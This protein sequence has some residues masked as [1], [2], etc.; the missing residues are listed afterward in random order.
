MVC[1]IICFE[2]A[3]GPLVRD[4]VRDGAEV[5]VVTTNNR[6]YRR[7][8]NSA[9]HVALGQM[10]AAETGRAVVQASISGISARIDPTG[11]VSHT[12]ELFE[13]EV[14]TS[15]V[16]TTT[17]QTPY[18]RYGD[19]VVWGS[20]IALLAAAVYGRLRWS[21]ATIAGRQ[22]RRTARGRIAS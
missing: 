12:T 9:Q 19:W 17:G 6:S 13:N 4:F 1:A 11:D 10:R 8:A 5:I 16:V 15:D 21:R 18:V 7:S 14:V 2:S 3:F 22:Y 20:A